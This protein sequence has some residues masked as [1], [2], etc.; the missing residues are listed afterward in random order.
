MSTKWF[1]THLVRSIIFISK[2]PKEIKMAYNSSCA[3]DKNEV[4][5]SISGTSPVKVTADHVLWDFNG[6][7]STANSHFTVPATG[8]YVFDI[9]L[10]LQ[11]LVNVTA[12]EL[13]LYRVGTGPGGADEYWFILGKQYVN[14]VD[15][16]IQITSFT[17]FD[18][19]LEEQYCI[20]VILSGVNPSAVVSGDASR[21]AWGFSYSTDMTGN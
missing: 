17:R 6:D 14:I 1:I 4:N 18:M 10:K 11:S 2:P 5:Q 20:K 15:S 16:E 8:I 13:A 12:V 21:S 19:V 7:Y 9:Q 3:V